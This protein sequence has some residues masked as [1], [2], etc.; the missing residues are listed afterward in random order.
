[1]VL[2]LQYNLQITKSENF[3]NDLNFCRR[4]TLKTDRLKVIGQKLSLVYCT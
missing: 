3:E 2:S 1:M 4:S